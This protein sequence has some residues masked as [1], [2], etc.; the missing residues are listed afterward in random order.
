M[1]KSMTG[2]G[3]TKFNSV[4]QTYNIDI[5]AINSKNL[6][7]IQKL[8]SELKDKEMDIRVILNNLL[9]RGKVDI[10][11]TAEIQQNQSFMFNEQIV[12]NNF[13]RLKTWIEDRHLN[14]SDADILGLTFKTPDIF[15]H[16]K[17]ETM[18]DE[19][20]QLL[21]QAIIK[22]C[23]LLNMNRESEGTALEQDFR[24]RIDLIIKYLQNI[25]DIENNRHDLIKNK[26][27]KQLS[28]L[29]VDYDKNRFEQELIFYLEKLDFTEEKTLFLFYRNIIHRNRVASW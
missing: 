26:L 4:S 20:W 12:E 23:E 16:T 13:Y 18:S 10:S 2:F 8:P 17:E 7:I 14:I 15:T 29:E 19:D 11:I 1:I 9:L 27:L 24:L 22:A 28:A 25:E 6:D 3:T 21:R 5:K